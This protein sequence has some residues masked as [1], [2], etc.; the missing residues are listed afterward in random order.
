MSSQK[1]NPKVAS[2]SDL[3]ISS[4]SLDVQI[5]SAALHLLS[6]LHP[7][8]FSIWEIMAQTEEEKEVMNNFGVWMN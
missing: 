8:L 6:S 7:Y 5:K 3:C 1:E 2:P 4:S